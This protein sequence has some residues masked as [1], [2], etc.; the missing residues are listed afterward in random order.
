VA[1]EAMSAVMGSE[2]FRYTVAVGLALRGA[3]G[4][5]AGAP[6]LDLGVGDSVMVERRM[7]PRFMIA[8]LAASGAILVGTIAAAIVVGYSISKANI[9]LNQNKTELKAL[10]VEHAAK[11]AA[12]ERQKTLVD[13]IRFRDRPVREAI[14]FL[15]NAVARRAAMTSLA[16]DQG[17]VISISGEAFTPKAV[18]DIMDTINLSPTLE[19]V[20]LQ[21]LQRLRG[22]NGA[23]GLRFDLQTNFVKSLTAASALPNGPNAGAQKPAGG[24]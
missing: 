19:P 18:A 16:L 10:T 3:G 8:S 12:L 13:A 11:V 2:G 1:P 9:R 22:E 15:S 20:R 7:A 24:S 23:Q 6:A 21:M 5:Y 14:D 4:E 17:G